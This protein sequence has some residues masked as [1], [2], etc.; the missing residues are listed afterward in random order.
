MNKIKNRFNEILSI[1]I[2]KT[3]FFYIID[4]EDKNTAEFCKN[5]GLYY[6]YYELPNM[7]FIKV[8]KD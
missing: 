2:R 4:K 3:F 1:S 6:I 7:Q 8:K 5:N